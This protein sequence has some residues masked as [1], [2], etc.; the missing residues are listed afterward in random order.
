M[1]NLINAVIL[2]FVGLIPFGLIDL[3]NEIFGWTVVGAIIG[4]ILIIKSFK[5]A[6][7]NYWNDYYLF[8]SPEIENV[9][10]G[11]NIFAT[12]IVGKLRRFTKSPFQFAFNVE[13]KYRGDD[14]KDKQLYDYVNKIKASLLVKIVNSK[15][16]SLYTGIEGVEASE[17][18]EVQKYPALSQLKG[19]VENT[20]KQLG[21]WI[22]FRELEDNPEWKEIDIKRFIEKVKT[23]LSEGRTYSDTLFTTLEDMGL[24]FVSLNIDSDPDE[25]TKTKTEELYQSKL[26]EKVVEQDAKNESKRIGI[27]TTRKAIDTVTIAKANAKAKEIEAEAE[28]IRLIREGEGRAAAEAEI[29]DKAHR[30]FTE[31]YKEHRKNDLTHKEAV[32]QAALSTNQYAK[33]LLI[34]MSN[35]DGTNFDD[36]SLNR[37]LGMVAAKF[38]LSEKNN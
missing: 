24:E 11:A 31:F 17:T 12:G 5:T 20:V 3:L 15:K 22:G 37:I 1:K 4:T 30:K 36:K 34:S 33:E 14:D 29:A 8:G 9:P 10:S 38:E 23:Q 2:F 32:Q 35:A 25:K 16:F 6:S 7:F 18:V 26:N 19:D 21:R 27:L 28:K 13:A